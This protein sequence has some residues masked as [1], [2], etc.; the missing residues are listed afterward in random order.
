MPASTAEEVTIVV[1]GDARAVPDGLPL[2]ALLRDAGID[3]SDARG[4]AVAVN[5]AVVRR[6]DWPDVTLA[7]GDRVEIIQ[8]QQGG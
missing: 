4:I 8:A 6:P 1:N 5:D 7:A 2:P 3:P